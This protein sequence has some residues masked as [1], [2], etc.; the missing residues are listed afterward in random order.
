M[1]SYRSTPQV[2]PEDILPVKQE[3]PQVLVYQGDI[4]ENRNFGSR[5][6]S[7]G[8]LPE[9]RSAFVDERVRQAVSL[10]Y[11]RDLYQNVVLTGMPSD[12]KRVTLSTTF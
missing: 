9:G 10:G 2:T 1:G 3:A 11:D 6:M 5:V 7:F 4:D 12:S 8:W